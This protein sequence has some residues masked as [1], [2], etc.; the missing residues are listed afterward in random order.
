MTVATPGLMTL[1][2]DT[3][4]GALFVGRTST[5]ALDSSSQSDW[6]S[7]FSTRWRDVTTNP[8]FRMLFSLGQ[9][10]PG[11]SRMAASTT[12]YVEVGEISSGH[13]TPGQDTG[14]GLTGDFWRLETTAGRD[15]RV[16]VVFGGREGRS[17]V[18]GSAGIFYLE[19]GDTELTSAS[20]NDHNRDD[21]YTF[22]HFRDWPRNWGRKYFLKVGAYDNQTPL[23]QRRSLTYHG[24]YEITME[25]ITGVEL[26]ASNL[27][28]GTASDSSLFSSVH[29]VLDRR[30]QSQATKLTTGGH[31][32]GYVLDG[33]RA[34]VERTSSHATLSIAVHQD[35]SGVPGT[36][37]CDLQVGDTVRSEDQGV[38]PV[39]F[40]APDCASNTLSANTSYWLVFSRPSGAIGVTRVRDTNTGDEKDLNLGAG[41]NWSIGDNSARKTDE[42]AWIVSSSTNPI[43]LE[44]WAAKKGGSRQQANNPAT[45]APGISGTPQSEETLTAT[46]AGIQD[47]DGMNGAVFTYQWVRRN[48]DTQTDEDIPAA[49]TST[50]TVTE[51]DEG[52]AL[53][54]R[55]TFTDD[56]GNEETLTSAAVIAAPPPGLELKSAALDGAALTL[57]Y[58]EVL[59]ESVTLPLDAFSVRVN[60]A[61]QTP[62]GASV[63]GTAVLLTLA[64]PAT[65]GDAVTLD[66][67]KPDGQHFIRDTQGRTAGSFS[68]HVVAN[69]TAVVLLTA[70]LHDAPESHNGQD[71][72]IFELRFSEEVS[73]GYRIL[74]DYAFTETG[75]TVDLARRLEAPSNIRWEIRVT[76][77]GD[78]AVTITLPVTTHCD[79]QRAVCTHDGRM[80]SSLLELT[81]TGP[82]SQQQAPDDDENNGTPQSPASPPPAPTGLTATVNGDGSG[83]LTWDAPDDDTVTGYRILRRRPA[84][85][86]NRLL[87]HVVNTGSAAATYTDTGVA[88]GTRHVYRVKA[89]NS[90]GAGAQSGYVNVDP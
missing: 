6:S 39:I 19:P 25:D 70:S 55:V 67:T 88:E 59:D 2:N 82:P 30:G 14:H 28:E 34:R 10:Y 13:L 5:D 54:V 32:A 15:H 31:A 49:T 63:T 7:P 80:L 26:F 1:A 56:D 81:V 83:T 84:E 17:A 75:G 43:M 16:R 90:A 60:G 8:G 74:R 18:G 57:N 50:Y 41:L 66:Y 64:S 24:R 44:I 3:G 73:I 78:G 52:R 48:L 33:I 36:K 76:P 51:G 86:E 45:G 89:V 61:S 46:T 69:D 68:G 20:S 22:V 11:S 21:G 27:H 23:T 85:G 42:D 62:T 72:F 53:K 47:Q 12:G 79:A 65:A 35:S 38:R 4:N 71:A 37:V 9:D 40:L 58:N 29:D 87:V 77:S